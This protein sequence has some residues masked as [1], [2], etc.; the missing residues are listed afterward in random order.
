LDKI[1]K[2]EAAKPV[3]GEVNPIYL[4]FYPDN[5]PFGTQYNG[6]TKKWI[7]KAYASQRTKFESQSNGYF[8][9]LFGFSATPSIAI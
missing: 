6:R 9:K 5:V 8:G 3:R 1:L 7:D 4:P 2:L